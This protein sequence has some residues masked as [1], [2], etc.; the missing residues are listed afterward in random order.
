MMVLG[1]DATGY[2]FPG[3]CPRSS[4]ILVSSISFDLS[5]RLMSLSLWI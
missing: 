4:S 3:V 2:I 5:F 1:K